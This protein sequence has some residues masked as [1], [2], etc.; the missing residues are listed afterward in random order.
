MNEPDPVLAQERQHVLS[1]VGAGGRP[2]VPG[3]FVE[4]HGAGQIDSVG[5]RVLQHL[6]QIRGRVDAQAPS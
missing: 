3:E 5:G 2:L 6:H 4:H 1:G